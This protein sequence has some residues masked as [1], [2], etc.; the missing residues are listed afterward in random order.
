MR[1]VEMVTTCKKSPARTATVSST[2]PSQ[3]FKM[4]ST[5][6]RREH[7]LLGE[8]PS[9]PRIISRPYE[10]GRQRTRSSSHFDNRFWQGFRR[11]AS[12]EDKRSDIFSYR[13]TG[14]RS[15]Y[16]SFSHIL[17]KLLLTR[18]LACAEA[19]SEQVS[20]PTH[21]RIHLF[22]HRRGRE[23]FDKAGQEDEEKQRLNRFHRFW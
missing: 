6:G 19:P 4:G 18:A 20:T 12:N 21:N 14:C 7:D 3:T 8:D 11:H 13:H 16:C 9:K 15:T 17:L 2:K 5:S 10:H 1:A 22:S 23:E